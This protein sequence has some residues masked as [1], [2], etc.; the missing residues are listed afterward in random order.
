MYIFEEKKNFL[1]GPLVGLGP[2]ASAEVNSGPG[3]REFRFPADKSK[4]FFEIILWLSE[5][6]W[7]DELPFSHNSSSGIV[8]ISAVQSTTFFQSKR[9]KALQFQFMC[10]F[11]EV[12]ELC[13]DCTST[14]MKWSG[15]ILTRPLCSLPT[16]HTENSP[17]ERA[18]ALW[19]CWSASVAS[20]S[21]L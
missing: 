9:F 7:L 12:V 21:F 20:G 10:V 4:H 19:Q 6:N 16:R 17:G 15:R 18:S 3:W 8:H 14:I 11:F 2:L 5:R 13:N 1:K